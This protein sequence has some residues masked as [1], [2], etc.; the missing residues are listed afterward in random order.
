MKANGIEFYRKWFKNYV[1]QFYGNV[2]YINK[3]IEIKENHTLRVCE[4]IIRLSKS[5]ELKDRDL[6]IAEIIALFH[7]IGRFEQFRDYNTFND[8]NSEDHAEMGVRILRRENILREF[9]A[10]V[11]EIIENSILMHNKRNLFRSSENNDVI[12]FSKLIRD[13]DKLDILK[14]LTEYY[15]SDS[16]E[17]NPALDLDLPESNEISESVAFEIF[18][19]KTLNVKKLKT[20]IDFKLLLISWIFDINF[21]YTLEIIRES[22]FIDKIFNTLPEDTEINKI[23]AHVNKYITDKLK[24]N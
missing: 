24:N 14:V 2:D 19:N 9:S 12:F 15:S 5:A 17:K 11:I 4:N 16:D 8:K 1:S 20:S 7:D 3:N 6:F 13:A 21:N 22:K 10:S 23:R 18:S